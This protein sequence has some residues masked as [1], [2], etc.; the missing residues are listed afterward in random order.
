MPCIKNTEYLLK[1]SGALFSMVDHSHIN[2][3]EATFPRVSVIIP[4]F[5]HGKYLA[6][7]IGSVLGQTFKGIEIIVVNDGSTDS[8]TIA[9]LDS[10]DGK[11]YRVIHIQNQGLAAARNAGI[12]CCRGEYILPLDADDRISQDF[13]RRAVNHL[14]VDPRLGV[15]YSKVR[16]F[17]E[18]EGVWEQ[19]EFSLGRILIE[20]MIVASAVFRKKD[21]LTVGGYRENMKEGWED[22]DFWLSLF[23]IPRKVCRLED[24]LF[25]YRIRVDSMTRSLLLRVKLKLFIR[26]ILNHKVLYFM[27]ILNLLKSIPAWM[28]DGRGRA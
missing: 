23:E 26:L 7:S 27:N 10:L 20:N 12:A 5:N 19:P 16:Y 4:C 8:E 25:Y 11:G 9:I 13:V 18:L 21:W 2:S 14:D 6:D 3:D 17:G 22:W 24:D 1:N 28:R 15:V